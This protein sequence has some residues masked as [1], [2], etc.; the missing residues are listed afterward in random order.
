MTGIRDIP[1]AYAAQAALVRRIAARPMGYKV[2]LTSPRMQAMC[3]VDQ[4]IAGVVMADRVHRTGAAI[5]TA[6]YN[7]LGIEFEIGVRL[8]R[9]LQAP[10]ADA[11]AV[12]VDG[13]CAAVELIDDSHVDYKQFDVLKCVAEN[14]WNAGIV[15]GEFAPAWGDLAAAEGIAYLNGAALDRGFGR[16]VLGHPFNSVA[17]LAGHVGGLR[18]GDV[19][20]TGSIIP[21]R[22]PAPGDAYRFTV[23]GVGEV[24]LTV[25]G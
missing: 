25:A 4:P 9:D 21:T 14:A 16:D 20:L 17:W 6:N 10:T 2:G 24:S 11:V 7:H 13:V 19:V 23:A 18:K 8:G 22:F 12:A 5:R 3:G 1:A 15:L